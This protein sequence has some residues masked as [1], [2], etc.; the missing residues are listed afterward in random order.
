MLSRTR[1][2]PTV[3]VTVAGF[4]VVLAFAWIAER[5]TLTNSNPLEPISETLVAPPFTVARTL[6]LA[7]ALTWAIPR[8]RYQPSY[9]VTDRPGPAAGADKPGRT[10]RVRP[11]ASGS[12]SASLA[13]GTSSGPQPFCRPV[14]APKRA[15]DTRDRSRGKE[16]DYR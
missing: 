16:G 1:I 8:L 11:A 7:A 3:R 13:A 2:Y 6:A 12:S 5:T 9:R 10:R 14:T 15:S 4:G